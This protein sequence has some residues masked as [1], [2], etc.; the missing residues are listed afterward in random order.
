MHGWGAAMDRGGGTQVPLVDR[1]PLPDKLLKWDKS[2]VR[3]GRWTIGLVTNIK[4]SSAIWWHYH[5]KLHLLI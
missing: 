5:R 2:I 1:P 3:L 4:I